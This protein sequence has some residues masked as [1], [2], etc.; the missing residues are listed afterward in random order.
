[1]VPP[2]L[3]KEPPDTGYRRRIPHCTGKCEVGAAKELFQPKSGRKVEFATRNNQRSQN[4]EGI[5]ELLD[6]KSLINEQISTSQ[7][8]EKQPISTGTG[9]MKENEDLEQM[10]RHKLKTKI[11][12]L[13]VVQKDL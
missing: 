8:L 3:V 12:I 11:D 2:S 6:E 5:Q 10:D 4:C 9:H 7:V 13:P 1:M